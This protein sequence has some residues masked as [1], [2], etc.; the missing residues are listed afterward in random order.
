MNADTTKRDRVAR[1]LILTATKLAQG[2]AA[3]RGLSGPALLDQVNGSLAWDQQ[4]E[5]DDCVR[6]VREMETA[7]YLAATIRGL[8]RGELF[9]LRHVALVTITARGQELYNETL[10]VDPMIDDERMDV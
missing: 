8:R 6:L 9:G 2:Y 3:K 4:L 5:A 7:G 1:R 10:P